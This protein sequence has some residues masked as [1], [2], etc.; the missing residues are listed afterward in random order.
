MVDRGE[1]PR[2]WLAGDVPRGR[3]EAWRH[4]VTEGKGIAGLGGSH[5]QPKWAEE[6]WGWPVGDE[7]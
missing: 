4:T 3:S 6:A 7:E 1:W 5:R 2:W